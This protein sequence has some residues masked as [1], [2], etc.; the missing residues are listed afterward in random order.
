MRGRLRSEQVG[1]NDLG[2]P[3]IRPTQVSIARV[4][5]RLQIA[6]DV[7]HWLQQVITSLNEQSSATVGLE[8][9]RSLRQRDP[10]YASHVRRRIFRFGERG[11]AA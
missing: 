2:L 6:S 11:K 1:P 3:S 8:L 5:A 9:H 10:I 4:N 7:Q